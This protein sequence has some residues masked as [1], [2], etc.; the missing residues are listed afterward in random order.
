VGCIWGVRGKWIHNMGSSL[1][2]WVLYLYMVF[3]FTREKYWKVQGWAHILY[4]FKPHSYRCSSISATHRLIESW[5]RLV[6]GYTYKRISILSYLRL[7]S[8]HYLQWA[9][10]Q[11]ETSDW[12][13]WRKPAE[14]QHSSFS[15]SLGCLHLLP[16][17]EV[18]PSALIDVSSTY[19]QKQTTPSLGFC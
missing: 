12:M 17:S 14:H 11:A 19:K 13:K 2:K 8:S 10:F 6:F 1:W 7:E 9:P 3:E 16:A 18:M 5:K 4:S 15:G